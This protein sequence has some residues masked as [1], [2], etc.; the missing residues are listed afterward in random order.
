MQ[1]QDSVPKTKHLVLL[2]GG[3]SHLA[4]L[5]HFAKN[6]LP[7]LAITLISRDIE[8]PYSG[9]LPATIRGDIKEEQ[10]HIDLRPL[11]QMARARIIRAQV[12]HVDAANKKIFC[13]GRPDI[14]F[15]IL[16]INIGSSPA[17]VAIK[18]A[19]KFALPI[20]PIGR[21]I[22]QWRGIIARARATYSEGRAHCIAIVGGGPASVELALAIHTRLLRELK[23]DTNNALAPKITLICRSAT[24]IADHCVGA[25]A[26]VT[27]ALSERGIQV[28]LQTTVCGVKADSVEYHD[29]QAPEAIQSLH[30]NETILATGSSAPTWLQETGIELTESGF[31]RVNESLQSVSQP[32][33]F[34]AGD[35]A[36]IDKHPRPKS[37][38][39]AVRQGQPL[40]DNLRRYAANAK[41]KR[42]VP[43]KSALALI[44]VSATNAIASRK[45]RSFQ[46][47]WVAIWK[48][49]IDR[50]FVAKY[51]NIPAPKEAKGSSIVFS[52]RP[53]LKKNQTVIRCSGCGAKVGADALRNVLSQL[54]PCTHED[55]LSQH[56]ETEDASIIQID[57][58]RLLLQSVDHF[59]AFINDPFVFARIATIHC[60]S[61]VHAMGAIPHSA[62]AIVSVPYASDAIMQSTL[63]ELMSECTQTLNEH[64]TALIGGHSSESSELSFGLSINAFIDPTKILR[65]S[66]ALAGDSLILCK[67]LGTGTLFAADMR[68]QAKQRWIEAALTHMQ[69]SNQKASQ[70][71]VKFGASACTDI[72]GFGLIGHLREMIEPQALSATLRLA[73]IPFIDGAIETIKK[74]YLSSLHEENLRNAA[75]VDVTQAQL[76]DPRAQLL[77]DPQTAGGLLAAIPKE[78]VEACLNE[79]RAAGYACAA[80]IGELDDAD[81]ATGARIH[82]SSSKISK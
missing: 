1:Q 20:K 75:P 2:G 3:H 30:V 36:A 31:I 73:A 12:K 70:C 56:P 6:P 21:F 79:L 49:W 40:A 9:S 11:A 28:L 69:V 57:D 25:Q 37:G 51:Q 63:L 26:A 55:I 5:M 80:C 16:S 78:N 48:N 22:I 14:S 7:G 18:G 15:D 60:L 27:K 17:S 71:F 59:R 53:G 82:L 67:P 43:Q 4:V 32:W 65:K 10:M 45:Q 66:T 29:K 46:G 74:G 39:Y 34:A 8:T 23:L 13:T 52:Q 50:R 54:T 64:N 61:D 77:F 58:S 68:Y 47:R 38:V 19:N 76:A 35:I 81:S 33:I 62:L 42:H 41:L 44:S 24:L 72:T